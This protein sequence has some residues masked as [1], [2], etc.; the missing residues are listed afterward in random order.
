M[1]RSTSPSPTAGGDR[2][3]SPSSS[4]ASGASVRDEELAGFCRD[5]LARYKVPKSFVTVAS[6]PRNATGKVIKAEL[7]TQLTEISG[8][9]A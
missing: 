2:S 6:L 7:R 1:P 3:G 4:A 5:R 9:H 8:G